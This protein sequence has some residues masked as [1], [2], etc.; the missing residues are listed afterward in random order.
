MITL[1][2][3]KTKAT[4]WKTWIAELRERMKHRDTGSPCVVRAQDQ[5]HQLLSRSLLWMFSTEAGPVLGTG[6]SPIYCLSFL[7]TTWR[8]SPSGPAIV[9]VILTGPFNK[10][11]AIVFALCP[12]KPRCRNRIRASRFPSALL[13]GFHEVG[14]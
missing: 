10:R 1:L 9:H 8:V 6:T 12:G 2:L 7:L 14:E 13:S 4:N 3:F 5:D 11:T